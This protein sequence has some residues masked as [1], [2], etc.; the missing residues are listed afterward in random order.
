MVSDLVDLVRKHYN[1]QV[2]VSVCEHLMVL[3]FKYSTRSG[4]SLSMV[5]F[6]VPSIK[7]KILIKDMQTMVTST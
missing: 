5:D 4:L 7:K 6:D 3:G 2:M 1:N